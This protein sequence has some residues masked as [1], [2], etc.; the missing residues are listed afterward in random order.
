MALTH[1]LDTSVYSHPLKPKP[2]PHVVR[3]WRLQGE[4]RLSV[5]AICEAEV[6]QGLYHKNSTRLWRA[7]EVELKGHFPILP[8]DA[9]VAD[10]YARRVA[11]SW[12]KGRPRPELDLLIAATAIAHDLIL[13]TLNP[14]DFEHIEGLVV[15]DWGS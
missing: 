6:L 1:L 3:R 8:I 5:S 15:E 7:Y 13:A 4:H 12:A 9:T 14:R 2:L 10:I 11:Q